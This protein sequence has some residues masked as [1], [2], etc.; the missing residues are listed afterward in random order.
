MLTSIVCLSRGPK[1][2]GGF[3]RRA[4]K[5]VEDAAFRYMRSLDTEDE[6]QPVPFYCEV[7]GKRII[8]DYRERELDLPTD[9]ELAADWEGY[10]DGR[11]AV[12]GK[13]EGDHFYPTVDRPNPHQFVEKRAR[14]WWLL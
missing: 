12:C 10:D 14:P 13:L 2:V 6:L 4:P 3:Y 8:I 5:A 1:T 11:C 9:E 7:N